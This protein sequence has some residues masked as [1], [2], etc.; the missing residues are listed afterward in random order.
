MEDP[1]ALDI[2][3]MALTNL[4]QDNAS[5]AQS[6]HAQRIRLRTGGSGSGGSE[7][8]VSIYELL[9]TM[10]ADANLKGERACINMMAL[11]IFCGCNNVQGQ[12]QIG[13]AGACEAVV[14]KLRQEQTEAATIRQGVQL[15]SDLATCHLGNQNR[16]REAGGI[17]LLLQFLP[18]FKK[19]ALDSARWLLTASML[20]E[21]NPANQQLLFSLGVVETAMELLQVYPEED[22]LLDSALGCLASIANNNRK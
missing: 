21:A 1:V 20:A 7:K 5:N 9:T 4:V 6:L 18:E 12:T 17:E 14:K 8:K 22:T 11:S 10:L 13:D 19:D 3:F 2:A 15:M 16:L